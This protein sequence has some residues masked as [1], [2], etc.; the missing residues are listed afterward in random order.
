V[1]ILAADIGGTKTL[2]AVVEQ[3]RNGG[4]YRLLAH[5]R[6]PS[7]GFS[8]LAPMID[9]FRHQFSEVTADI[10]Q[11][12]IGIAGPVN[13]SE[14][15]ANASI[16]NL[17]WGADERELAASCGV[18]QVLLINDFEAI[19][20]SIPVLGQEQL[21][22]IQP[23]EA[24]DGG[25]QAVIGP[26]TGLGQCLRIACGDGARVVATEGGHTSFSPQNEEQQTL[27]RHLRSQYD[28]VSCERLLSGSGLVAIHDYLVRIGMPAAAGLK[29]AREDGSDLAAAIGEA[30]M[31]GHDPTSTR[32]IRILVSIL[33]AQAGNLA[34]TAMTTGGIYIAGGI[35]PKLLDRRNEQ[36]L[37]ESFNHKGRMS[38]ITRNIPIRLITDPHAPLFGACAALEARQAP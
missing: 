36:L 26:G 37:L 27:L 24:V 18:Q 35:A 6:Y 11:I 12:A 7:A 17:D 25:V 34:L 5:H 10:E 21:R 3:E 19:G 31:S 20:H 38:A 14:S 15:G 8:S 23:G 22:V 2:L 9:A 1:K 32:A 16:T 28:H 33:G 30:G 13:R 4:G 29:Q